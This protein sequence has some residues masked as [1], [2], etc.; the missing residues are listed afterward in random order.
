VKRKLAA[1]DWADM[2]AY[3]QAKSEFVEEVIARAV[4]QGEQGLSK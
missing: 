2:N 1:Q 3:A 4:Q